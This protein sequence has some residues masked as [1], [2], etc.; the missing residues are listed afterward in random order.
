MPVIAPFKGL[1][2]ELSRVGSLAKVVTPPYDIISP[3][4]QRRLYRLH[5]HNFVRVVFGRGYA[6][7]HSQNNRYAR[8]RQTLQRWVDQGILKEDSA[9]SVYPYLQEYRLGGKTH[10]RW[11]MIALVRL[12]SPGIYPHERTRRAPKQDRIRLLAAARASLSPIF[13]LIPDR[14]KAYGRMI[15]QACRSQ[16]PVG[17]ARLDGVRHVLWRVSDPRRISEL[18]NFLKSK[19]LVIADGHHRFE[20]ALHYQRRRARHDRSSGPPAPYRYAMFYLASAGSEEPGLLPTHRLMIRAGRKRIARLLDDLKS[21]GQVQAGLSVEGLSSRLAHS[22]RRG[23]VAIGLWASQ[24]R[25]G[26]LLTPNSSLPASSLDVEWLH[27]QIL[28]RWMGARSEPVF[29]Q[30]LQAALRRVRRM[31]ASALFVM[32]P[33]RL[34]QVFSRAREGRRMPGK[35]TYF[36]PKPLAGLVEYK[37]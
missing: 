32:Q 37:F 10:R 31:P 25:R 27:H 3:E 23:K 28:P 9:A 24:G 33:P 13:G 11:G 7:D 34:N 6:R 15:R 1:R 2:Y 35:T 22:A 12:D 18:K 4:G 20:A 26:Y 8:A 30:D 19:D 5:A 17:T 21:H 16:A 14:R 29:T 36:Y